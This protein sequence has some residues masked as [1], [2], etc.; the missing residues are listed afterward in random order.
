MMTSQGNER[1]V[2]LTAIP[3]AELNAILFNALRA[4]YKFQQSKVA[5]FNLDYE[6]IYLMQLLRNN[7][8]VR[9]G[10]IAEEMSI[11]ISTATR[12]V[13]RLQQMG[14]VSRKK[15]PGDR[16]TVLVSL[17]K[18]GEAAVRK[19]EEHTF[20]VISENL[21]GFTDEEIASFLKTAVHL[22]NILKSVNGTSQ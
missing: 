16:R 2:M 11:P 15:D 21:A 6:D 13:D 20:S 3:R 9:M 1:H 17:E 18:K 4:I 12:V 22:G 5:V 7:S 8:P 14:L 10:E 19:I